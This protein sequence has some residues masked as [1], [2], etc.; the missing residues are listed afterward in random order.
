MSSGYHV[1]VAPEQ[2]AQ[3]TLELVE[4]VERSQPAQSRVQ[5]DDKVIVTSWSGLPTRH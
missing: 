2:L 4:V 5:V 1:D 3:P